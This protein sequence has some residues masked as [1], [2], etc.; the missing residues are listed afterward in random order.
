MILMLLNCCTNLITVKM[1]P[2]LQLLTANYTNEEKLLEK[3][4]TWQHKIVVQNGYVDRVR[5]TRIKGVGE[6][7]VQEMSV[8]WN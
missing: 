5:N 6:T 8:I 4:L 3:E 1:G 2:K 7:P